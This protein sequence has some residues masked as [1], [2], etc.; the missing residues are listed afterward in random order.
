MRNINEALH[1]HLPEVLKIYPEDQ[2]LGIF[3]YGSQNYKMDLENS[4][5]VGIIIALVSTSEF[6]ISIL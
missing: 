1:E 3:L 2:I 4:L 6:S 5:Y